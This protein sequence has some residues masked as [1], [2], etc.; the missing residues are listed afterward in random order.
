MK[1]LINYDSPLSLISFL[2]QHGLGMQK[3]FGQNFLINPSV[4]TMLLNE[5]EIFPGDE[6]WEIG[7]GLGA[8][9]AGLLERDAH[10]S[11]FEI[12]KG[13]CNALRMIF[14]NDKKFLLIEGDAFITI[15]DR[16]LENKK[17]IKMLG[18][19]PYNIAAK[20]LGNFIEQRLMFSRLVITV[21]REVAQRITA[22]PG[23]ADYSS[24]SVL[25]SSSY[26][27]KPLS[28]LK[29]ECFF[30][31]PHVESQSLRLDLLPQNAA[32][33]PLFYPM[34]RALFATRRKTI[35]NNLT[36]FMNSVKPNSGSLAISVLD[37]LKIEP[38]RRAE[39]LC[40]EDFAQLAWTLQ[41]HLAVSS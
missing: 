26:K 35:K 14:N 11:A 25:V 4:R 10:V 15:Q 32:P 16:Y 36:A 12:D 13:F 7:A 39:M 20:L 6:V 38:H 1:D 31:S 37:S 23:G 28:V 41:E 18:N 30:P 17:E 9:T 3:K 8:M 2:K 40:C 22:K 33:P 5:L 27:I 19:L 21:Q 24:L 34:L 29:G